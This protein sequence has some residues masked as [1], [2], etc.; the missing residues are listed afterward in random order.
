[1]RDKLEESIKP[2]DDYMQTYNKYA[3]E[4]K[5]DPAGIIKKLDDDDNPPEID[6][7]RKDVL[8]HKQ[9]AERLSGEIPDFL[10]VSMF[11][12][13][14]KVIR[15][16][17]ADKHHKIAEDEIELIAKRAKKM[18]NELVDIFEKMDMKIGS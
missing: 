1:M 11:K 4:Y 2:L 12:I 3:N 5:L 6:Y 18:A 13:S 14:S 7:L 15:N 16:N 17:L 8:F 9:E 10:I